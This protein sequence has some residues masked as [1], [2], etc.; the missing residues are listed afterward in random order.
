MPEFIFFNSLQIETNI[1]IFW[2]H[3]FFSSFQ[4]LHPLENCKDLDFFQVSSMD[5]NQQNFWV[6]SQYPDNS[7]YIPENVQT[8]QKA[9]RVDHPWDTK[10]DIA[11]MSAWAFVSEDAT[12]GKNQKKGA[13]FWFCICRTSRGCQ[14]RCWASIWSSTSSFCISSTSMSC[15]GPR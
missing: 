12:R 4:Y 6:N 11:L 10:K 1:H 3:Q 7:Q 13:L 5:P 14:K 9:P 8:S 2:T 15:L